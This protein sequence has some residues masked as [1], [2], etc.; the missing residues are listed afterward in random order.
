MIN[1]LYKTYFYDGEENLL[2]DYPG[3]L[4][5]PLYKNMKITIHSHAGDFSVVEWEFHHGHPDEESGLR[6][7]L[8]KLTL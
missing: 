3:I 6:I 4:P 2:C 5:I 1:E 7:I 8:K